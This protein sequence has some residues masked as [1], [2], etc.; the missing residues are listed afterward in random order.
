MN[1]AWNKSFA[2]MDE[3]GTVI[4][5]LSIANENAVPSSIFCL[6]NL[7]GL[8]IM[9]TPFPDGNSSRSTNSHT[10]FYIFV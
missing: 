1:D 10:L 9:R 3:N 6:R 2:N 7:Q 4:S 5:L 8:R